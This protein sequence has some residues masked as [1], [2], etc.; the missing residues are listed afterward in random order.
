MMLA[1]SS[2]DDDEEEDEEMIEEMG[3][4]LDAMLKASEAIQPDAEQGQP[5]E[6]KTHSDDDDWKHYKAVPHCSEW[7]LQMIR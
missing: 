7:G 2:S 5:V 3:V 4:S 6:A 1:A